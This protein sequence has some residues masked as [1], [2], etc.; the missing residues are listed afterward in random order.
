[1]FGLGELLNNLSTS[2]EERK[3]TASSSVCSMSVAEI[4][5]SLVGATG[6]GGLEV[7]GE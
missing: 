3:S 6:T 2:E 4:S 5:R 7:A 1:M